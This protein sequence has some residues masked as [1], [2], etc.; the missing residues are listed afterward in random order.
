MT[1]TIRKLGPMAAATM[2]VLA[3]ASALAI[4]SDRREMTTAAGACVPSMP[5]TDPVRHRVGGLRNAGTEPVYVICSLEAEWQSGG[6][7]S[8]EGAYYA[9]VKLRNTGTEA[10]TGQ[11]V[12][13]TG[14]SETSTA[15]TQ[16]AFVQTM[17]IA[18]GD[19]YEF[20]FSASSYLEGE[21]NEFATPTFICKLNQKVELIYVIRQFEETIGA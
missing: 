6:G 13:H 1:P 21:G 20:D 12:L 11:C 18:A 19:E 3:S 10:V 8:K 5:T 14:Y 7:V 17:G 2:A 16:G 15:T 9:G 4:E